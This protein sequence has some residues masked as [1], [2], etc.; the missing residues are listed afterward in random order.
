VPSPAYAAALIPVFTL[1][2]PPADVPPG[3]AVSGRLTGPGDTRTEAVGTLVQR[4]GLA[5]PF[6]GQLAGSRSRS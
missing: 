2:Q 5:L 6:A 4:T 3:L 1:L